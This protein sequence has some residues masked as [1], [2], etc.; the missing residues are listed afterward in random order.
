MPWLIAHHL[1]THLLWGQNILSKTCSSSTRPHTQTLH[2]LTPFLTLTM[3]FSLIDK[4]L[5]QHLSRQT[6]QLDSQFCFPAVSPT[7]QSFLH[8]DTRSPDFPPP[9][10][11]QATNKDFF[12]S[13]NEKQQGFQQF[14]ECLSLEGGTYVYRKSCRDIFLQLGIRAYIESHWHVAMYTQ[15]C[16]F[17]HVFCR[18]SSYIYVTQ[19]QSQHTPHI[20]ISSAEPQLVMTVWKLSR[21]AETLNSNKS[22]YLG[23]HDL[24]D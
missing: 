21:A 2:H 15:S 24:M 6:A 11:F 14:I 13:L 16:I 9:Q 20:N 22:W 4:N 19:S 18:L 5:R 8:F 1:I 3:F 7:R 23:E 17:A 10:H 12:H